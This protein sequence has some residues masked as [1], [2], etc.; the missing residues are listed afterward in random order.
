[1]TRAEEV[2]TRRESDTGIQRATR[3]IG[4][5]QGKFV[6]YLASVIAV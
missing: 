3:Q 4:H 1:M 6:A 2:I 5:N